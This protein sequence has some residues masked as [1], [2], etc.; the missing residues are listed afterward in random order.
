MAGLQENPIHSSGMSTVSS[1]A[2][3]FLSSL[4]R[5]Q[6]SRPPTKFLT[7]FLKQVNFC[8]MESA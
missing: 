6:A 5:A 3:N 1:R 4:A 8:C 2:S 7:T